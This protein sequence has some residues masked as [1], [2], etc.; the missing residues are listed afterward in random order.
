[1]SSH[2]KKQ[3]TYGGVHNSGSR[4]LALNS[5]NEKITVVIKYYGKKQK[6]D[7]QSTTNDLLHQI[8]VWGSN[9]KRR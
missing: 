8:F 4:L 9:S 6:N 2:V 7:I 3:H 5:V 1:V